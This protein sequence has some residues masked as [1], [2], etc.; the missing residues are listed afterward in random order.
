MSGSTNAHRLRSGGFT[1]IEL[2]VVIAIIAILAAMLLP[3][4]AVAK[5]KAKDTSCLSNVK[6]ITLAGQMYYEDTGQA[7]GYNDGSGSGNNDEWMGCLLNY[8]AKV[9]NLLMCPSTHPYNGAIDDSLGSGSQG[10]ANTSWYDLQGGTGTTLMMGSYG[11]NGWLYDQAAQSEYG[12]S[13][14]GVF[15]RHNTIPRPSQTPY[16]FDSVWVDVW[17]TPT[18]TPPNN[19]YQGIDD[20]SITGMDRVCISRHGW[21]KDPA[22]APTAVRI[23]GFM[24]GGVNMGLA[25]GHAELAKLMQLWNYYWSAD[26]VPPAK[27]P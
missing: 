15:G 11:I 6:Q 16:F 9:T 3:A 22:S 18:D 26:W 27:I 14:P 20:L 17:P 5:L 12:F 24:P 21:G 23:G 10:T 2:L 7:F 19:L 25:D 1:L 4:L 8:Y 13:G